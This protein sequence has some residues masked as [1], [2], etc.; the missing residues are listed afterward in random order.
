ELNQ[1]ISSQQTHIYRHLTTTPEVKVPK[2]T[3][4]MTKLPANKKN[5]QEQLFEQISI[6]LY[7]THQKLPKSQ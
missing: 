7:K 6:Q 5:N 2:M 4:P 1:K 3:K